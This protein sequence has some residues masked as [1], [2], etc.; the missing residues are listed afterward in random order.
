MKRKPWLEQR[1]NKYL[2]TVITQYLFYCH[3]QTRV[4]RC[5]YK[6]LSRGMQKLKKSKEHPMKQQQLYAIR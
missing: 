2:K 4:M 3:F 1:M 5:T 6:N